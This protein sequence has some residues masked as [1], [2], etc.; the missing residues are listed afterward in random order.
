M[1]PRNSISFVRMLWVIAVALVIGTV[2]VRI[3]RL[4]IATGPWDMVGLIYDDAYYYLTVAANTVDSGR[5]TLDGSTLTN[6]YQPLWFVCVALLGL[7]IGTDAMR[8]FVGF[9]VLICA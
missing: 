5:S 1:N 9:T 7:V 4:S 6:G 3:W 2:A 8:Y